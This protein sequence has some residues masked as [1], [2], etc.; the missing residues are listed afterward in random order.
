VDRRRIN[1]EESLPSLHARAS[2][3]QSV[4]E[5]TRID[6]GRGRQVGDG[7][8]IVVDFYSEGAQPNPHLDSR[9]RRLDLTADG[10]AALLAFLRA[11]SGTVTVGS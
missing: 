4:P 8:E 1:G 5:A 6:D 3:A 11:L 7:R 9:I 10:K 2:F